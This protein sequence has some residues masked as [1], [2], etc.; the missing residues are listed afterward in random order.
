VTLLAICGCQNPPSGTTTA[1]R[2][3]QP[4]ASPPPPAAR[5]SADQDPQPAPDISYYQLTLL[6]EPSTESSSTGVNLVRL[7]RGQ[8]RSVGEALA[9]LI[10][11][12]G[13]TGTTHRYAL[14]YPT[15]LEWN[16]ATEWAE[17]LDAPVTEE[18]P[19]AMPD[20]PEGRFAYGLGLLYGTPRHHDKAEQR[21]RLASQAFTAVAAN[22]S[23][24][25]PLRWA[26]AMLDGAI[27]AERLFDDAE[28]AARYAQAEALAVP[29][30]YEQMAAIYPQSVALVQ[31]G[32]RREASRLLA[33]VLS[34][35]SAYRATEAYDRARKLFGEVSP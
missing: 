32:R 14:L 17:R 16:L 26:A 6:S 10:I 8:A 29:G 22:G 23:A 12:S 7:N 4:K 9:L 27:Y 34:E 15:D 25:Q 20:N 30:S 13:P 28:A 18:E 1:P 2:P 5:A 19:P 21:C 35:F 31:E 33:R 3:I 11:P 24:S